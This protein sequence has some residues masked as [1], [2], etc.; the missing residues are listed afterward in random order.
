[1][2]Y[3]DMSRVYSKTYEN[4]TAADSTM[5]YIT[6]TDPT[7][8]PAKESLRGFYDK[9]ITDLETAKSLIGTNDVYHLNKAAV[10]GLLSRVYLYKG[11][12]A[13]CITASN[14][15][16]GTTPVLPDIATFP[17]IWKD[18][19]SSGVLFKI[20][21]TSIDNLN[22]LGVNYY[23]TVGGQKKSEYLVEYNFKQQFL[24]NDIR[25]TTYIQTG[26]F[27]GQSFNHVIKYAGRTGE[28]DGVLDAKVIRTAE[29]LLNRAEANYRSSNPSAAL[30][31]LLLLKSNRYTSYDPTEATGNSDEKLS[32][33]AL[34]DEIYNQRR[35]ELAFEGDR[36]WDLKRRNLPVLRDGTKGDLANGGGVPYVF[37]TLSVGDKRFLLPFPS[38]EVTFNTNLRQNPGY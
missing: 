37:T 19:T 20:R 15:A 1:M 22:T 16:L 2:T 33:T 6:T 5:P 4:A 26:L 36:F 21:N 31:D 23:Q 28:P 34:L 3:F 29:V 11:D 24:V 32:G 38:A 35:L 27:N 14:D 10:S 9:V 17:A 30:T 25:S 13:K 8:M 18:A 12:F 7:I